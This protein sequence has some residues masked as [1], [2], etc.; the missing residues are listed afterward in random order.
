MN[1]R[2]MANRLTQTVNA[3]IQITLLRS[4]GYTV[5]ANFKQ[6]PKQIELSGEAQIQALA[7]KDLQHVNNLNIQGVLRKVYLY[8]NWMG[9]VRADSKGGDVLVFPQAPCMGDQK[10]KVVTVLETW[11]DWCAVAVVLQSEPQQ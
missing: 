7:G 8:G 1:L 11:P 3:N 9:V 6:V 10:W 5:G 4:D 2:G